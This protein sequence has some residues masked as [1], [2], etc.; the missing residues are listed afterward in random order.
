MS[1]AAGLTP[2]RLDGGQACLL[3]T[4]TPGAGKTTVANGVARSLSRSA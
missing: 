1:A 2:D 4:G 3:I